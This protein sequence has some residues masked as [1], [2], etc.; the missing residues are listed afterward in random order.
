[1]RA[2]HGSATGS[3]STVVY[4]W[5]QSVAKSGYYFDSRDV[6]LTGGAPR[7]SGLC[8]L[9]IGSPSEPASLH[10]REA[11]SARS[12]PSSQSSARLITV[13]SARTAVN[14]RIACQVCSS[15][16]FSSVAAVL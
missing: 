10:G 5:Q 4:R 8:D 6:A 9:A 11:G 7:N 14:V 12:R 2:F 3:C 13:R 15:I 1:M 16:V